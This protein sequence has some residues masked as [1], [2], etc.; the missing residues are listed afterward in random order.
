MAMLK[1]QYV[2][3]LIAL[4]PYDITASLLVDLFA[5]RAVRENGE[6]KIYPSKI[7]SSDTFKLEKGK[8]ANKD[9]VTTNAGL[10]IVNKLLY[11]EDF[12]NILGYINEPITNKVHKK[13]ESKLSSALMND[14]ITPEQFAKYLNRL[15]W[16][17]NQMN[18]MT[19]TSFTPNTI[20]PL[21]SAMKMRDKMVKENREALDNG[22]VV[23]SIEIENAIKIEAKQQLSN[24][25]GMNLY[26]S[27][28]RGSFDN[29]Y[30]NMFLMKGSVY[31][32]GEGSYKFVESNLMEGIH[33]DELPTYGTA[34]INAAYPK[35][36]GTAKSGDM[37][38]Q[39]TAAFQ[40]V[41]VDVPGSDCKT[42]NTVK[43]VLPESR[44]KEFVGRHIVERG[45][46]VLLT[47]E[48]I[49]KYT[50]KEVNLRS[51]M[52]CESEKICSVCSD[53]K[54]EQLGI[55]NI[56]LTAS[57]MSGTLLNAGMKNFH[58]STVKVT[59]ININEITL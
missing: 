26:E 35:S 20:K 34:V 33:K 32:P 43:L 5:D 37:S 38:K 47:N 42:K 57:R 21:P 1:Q 23:K 11:E 19:V 51:P 46:L 15:Q 29:N 45:K 3:Q 17:G 27:G 9:T 52:Y 49:S 12:S 40:G 13:I 30:K 22:D 24:D 53:R 59:K 56:G 54:F 18:T 58:D 36:V 39:L 2:N 48:N 41:V 55:T 7:K 25:P 50:N 10:F 31:H 28:A 8:A 44:A 4:T 6:M 14:E 16:F